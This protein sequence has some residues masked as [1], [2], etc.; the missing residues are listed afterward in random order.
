MSITLDIP[1]HIAESV[2]VPPQEVE[3]RL[4]LE[5]AIALYTQDLLTSAKACALAG[6]T[7][8]E[9]ETT[10]G[11]RQVPRHYADAD[12]AEDLA[13]GQRGQ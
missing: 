6:L 4:R 1:P 11:K 13:Y 3:P 8:A 12:L 10:L 5:L 9:W 2:R 7:R